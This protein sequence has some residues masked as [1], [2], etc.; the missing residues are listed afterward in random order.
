VG[1]GLSAAVAK[2]TKALGVSADEL[3][4]SQ[5]TGELARRPDR[6]ADCCLQEVSI[7]A[8]DRVDFRRFGEYNEI[9]IGWIARDCVLYVGISV[10]RGEP[11]RP[12]RAETKTP[13]STTTRITRR[14]GAPGARPPAPHMPPARPPRR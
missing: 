4:S 2:L 5:T 3:C 11:E 9:V 12:M 13:G 14:D 7:A 1:G 8:D 6:Y 10:N